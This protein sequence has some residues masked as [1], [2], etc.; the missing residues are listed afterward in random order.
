MNKKISLGLVLIFVLLI[1]TLII[2]QSQFT[3]IKPLGTVDDDATTSEELFN[4]DQLVPD[5]DTPEP[6]PISE[7]KPIECSTIKQCLAAT[8]KKFSSNFFN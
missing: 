5:E 8:G 4:A 1:A 3:W 7:G 2:A 6:P